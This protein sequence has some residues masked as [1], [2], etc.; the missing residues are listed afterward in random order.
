[1]MSW[2]V[3]M[4]DGED[5]EDAVEVIATDAERAIDAWCE[6]ESDRDYPVIASGLDGLLVRVIAREHADAG[7]AA[8]MRRV[9]GMPDVRY[10]SEPTR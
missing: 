4:E 2:L 9:F 7:A 8:E 1:M 6:R 10:W 5:V 3:W